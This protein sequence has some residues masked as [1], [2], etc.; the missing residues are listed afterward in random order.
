M[1]DAGR[2]DGIKTSENP[3][4]HKS[5]GNTGENGQVIIFRTLETI[6]RKATIPGAF[7]KHNW[8]LVRTVSF[9]S[10]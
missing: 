7:K 3:L 2:P 9:A 8:I 4:F 5:K 1:K 10:L 6:Q